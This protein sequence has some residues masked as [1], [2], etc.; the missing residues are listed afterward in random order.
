MA[1]PAQRPASTPPTSPGNGQAP[2]A[3]RMALANVTR[4]RV[5]RP[6][7]VLLYGPPGIGKTTWAA[8]APDVLLL[9]VES[10]SDAIDVARLPQPATFDEVLAAVRELAQATHDYKTFA[11]DTIDALEALIWRHVCRLASVESIEEVGGG[12]GKGYGEALHHWRRL[13]KGLEALRDR[14]M[15]VILIGH[16]DVRSWKNPLGPDFDRYQLRLHQKVAAVVLD[17]CDDVLFCNL[18]VQLDKSKGKGKWAKA[19]AVGGTRVVRTEPSPAY[20]AKNR[21]SLPARLPLHFADYMVALERGQ[22]STQTTLEKAIATMAGELGDPTI[23]SWVTSQMKGKPAPALMQKIRDRLQA[24]LEEKEQMEQEARDASGE[25][26]PD[27]NNGE[28]TGGEPD[29]GSDGG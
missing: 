16:A 24:K 26:D 23:T 21:H 9:P 19:K 13:L 12:Y 7:R 5:A 6:P 28:E 22:P 18:E 20:E 15:T 11:L 4:G 1:L 3:S 8:G 27:P 10:G 17:W 14:G 2:A 29:P 25:P